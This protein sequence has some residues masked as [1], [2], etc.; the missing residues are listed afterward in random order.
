MPAAG[1]AG[2]IVVTLPTPGAD[3]IADGCVSGL[4]SAILQEILDNPGGYYVNVHNGEFPDGA[5]R[6][7]LTPPPI[8]LFAGMTAHRRCPAP[9]IRTARALPRST[10]SS[11]GPRL[12][13]P[14][15]TGDPAATAAHVHLGVAGI[16]GPVIITL[17]TPDA[18]GI[19]AGCVDGVDPS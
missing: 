7:Q 12:R 4:D 2:P 18:N 3:G 10:S 1:V 15:V 13:V 5:I 19:A 14:R 11:M 9:A 8:T 17:P 16:A 6:G